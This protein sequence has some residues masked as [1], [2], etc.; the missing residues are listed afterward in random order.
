MGSVGEGGSVVPSKTCSVSSAF[1][2]RAAG[3]TDKST[4][5]DPKKGLF[6]ANYGSNGFAVGP[7][8]Y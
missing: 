2:R 5:A 7:D 8:I 1:P 6:G 4:F 3:G